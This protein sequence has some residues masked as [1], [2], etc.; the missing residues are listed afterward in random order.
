VG[1]RLP[2]SPPTNPT[3]WSCSHAW[4]CLRRSATTRRASLSLRASSSPTW[5]RRGPPPRS[6]PPGA[7]RSASVR[8]SR[9]GRG[10][11]HGA[12]TDVKIAPSAHALRTL[13]DDLTLDD[14]L[15]RTGDGRCGVDGVNGAEG[16]RLPGLGRWSLPPL[17]LSGGVLA[18]V[19]SRS[20]R[21]FTACVLYLGCG[22]TVSQADS[23]ALDSLVDAADAEEAAVCRAPPSMD[24]D[25]LCRTNADCSPTKYCIPAG[26]C[27]CPGICAERSLSPCVSERLCGCDGKIY[28]D[29]CV[30]ALSGV[31]AVPCD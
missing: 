11:G 12:S 8:R 21:M 6:A 16:I 22:G 3:T 15:L 24:A 23:G 19:Q 7:S 5:A 1:R 13:V 18:K 27:G 25:L 17:R 31:Y 29:S 2:L 28:S 10:R 9:P 26:D 30:A 14:V 20:L 4:A